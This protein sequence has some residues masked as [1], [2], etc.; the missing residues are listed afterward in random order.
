MTGTAATATGSAKRGFFASLMWW[1]QSETEIDNQTRLYA[2]LSIWKSARGVSLLCC[3]LTAVLTVALSHLF[4]MT[5]QAAMIDGGIW[6]ALGF[7]MYAGQ[8]WAFVIAMILWTLEKLGGIVAF[9]SPGAP[10]AQIIWWAAYMNAFY[11]GFKVEGRRRAGVPA[12]SA[13]V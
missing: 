3:C 8:R 9:A 5:A 13:R 4:G 11:L 1:K 12:T 7:L 2:T 10:I 6:L